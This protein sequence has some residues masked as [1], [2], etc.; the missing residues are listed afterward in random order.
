MNIIKHKG[1][2]IQVEPSQLKIKIVSQSACASCD[3][4]ASC[5][6]MECRDKIV[7]VKVN[8]SQDYYIDQEVTV[9]MSLRSGFGAVFWGYVL[10][11]ILVLLTLF[12]AILMGYSESFAGL[13]SIIILIPY[14]FGLFLSQRYF[15]D[16][17]SFQVSAD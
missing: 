9:S 7:A 12:A 2:V 13:S 5:G 11:L 6:L 17:F 15:N 10:P 1:T 14:Y 16:K 4:R 8:N 3:A